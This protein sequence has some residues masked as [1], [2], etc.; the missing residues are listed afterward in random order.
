MNRLCLGPRNVT[1]VRAFVALSAYYR[2]FQ[3]NF[4][5]IAAPLYELTRKL[6]PFVWDER[7]QTA[8]ERMRQAL[9]SP[10]ILALLRDEGGMASRREDWSNIF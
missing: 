5:D 4:S 2:K 6:E 1:D 8:F 10:T 7:R 9:V 3:P